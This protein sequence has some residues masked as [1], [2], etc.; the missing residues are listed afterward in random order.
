VCACACKTIF[1]RVMTLRKVPK[2]MEEVY[3]VKI[4]LTPSG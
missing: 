1:E 2:D 3:D 4:I